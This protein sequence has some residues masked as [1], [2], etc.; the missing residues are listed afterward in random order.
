ME[1][2]QKALGHAKISTTQEYYDHFTSDHAARPACA[3][4]IYHARRPPDQPAAGRS[5]NGNYKRGAALNPVLLSGRRP[6]R[7]AGKLHFASDVEHVTRPC[8]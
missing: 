3:R 6:G 4:A 1:Q 5:S 7:S 2:L 8:G